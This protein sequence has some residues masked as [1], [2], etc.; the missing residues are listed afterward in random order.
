MKNL[1]F[2]TLVLINALLSVGGGV[3]FKYGSKYTSGINLNIIGYNIS[4][5]YISVIGLIIYGLSFLVG[6]FLVATNDLSKLTPIGNGLVFIFATLAGYYIFAETIT[7][8]KLFG[9]LL[10]LLGITFIAIKG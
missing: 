2:F 5:S 9:I 3:I 4:I 6:M 10:I 8:T 7:L 1:V